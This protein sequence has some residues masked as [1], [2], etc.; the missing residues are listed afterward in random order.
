MLTI[1]KY[2]TESC[3]SPREIRDFINLTLA[4][5]REALTEHHVAFIDLEP[6]D[7]TRYRLFVM[8]NDR[9]TTIGNRVHPHI[10]HFTP[11]GHVESSSYRVTKAMTTW[12]QEAM[13]WTT[14]LWRQL[15][16]DIKEREVSPYYS[17]ET[18]KPISMG[19]E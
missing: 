12:R 5:V 4:H 2:D 1:F 13:S 11:D 16:A 9:G 15:E 14:S 8:T 7:G 3:N 6:G 17:W 19:S 10:M 18:S